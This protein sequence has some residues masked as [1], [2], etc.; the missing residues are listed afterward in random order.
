MG[1][2]AHEPLL[3]ASLENA[4]T[5]ASPPVGAAGSLP[6][7]KVTYRADPN[8]NAGAPVWKIIVAGNKLAAAG[9]F[10]NDLP[11]DRYKMAVIQRAIWVYESRGTATP[12][13]RDTL[14]ADIRKQV[15]ETGGTQTDAQIQDLVNH[16][17]DDVNAVLK[18][19]GL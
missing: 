5:Y 6:P 18:S 12:H 9:K 17:M 14:L 2:L 15:K 10:H 8:P 11:P 16:I 7:A 1:L 4:A 13:T 19:A 3:V